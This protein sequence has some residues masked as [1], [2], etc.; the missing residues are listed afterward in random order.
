LWLRFSPRRS[1]STGLCSLSL[2]A[3]PSPPRSLTETQPQT[4]RLTLVLLGVLSS[5]RGRRKKKGRS[6]QLESDGL[7]QGA[8]F[9]R[10]SL[11]FTGSFLRRAT[12]SLSRR[13]F[14]RAACWA[15]GSHSEPK[16]LS[17][18]LLSI[19][20]AKTCLTIECC[21]KPLPRCRRKLIRD[22]ILGVL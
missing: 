10:H 22:N 3:G 5:S 18:E 21:A 4:S 13:C 14:L 17:T 11:K 1:S 12:V 9:L 20:R 8:R 15:P 7:F 2:E 6:D 16:S 19:G